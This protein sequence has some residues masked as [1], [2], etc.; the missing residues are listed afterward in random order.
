MGVQDTFQMYGVLSSCI[1]VYFT[2]GV[3]LCLFAGRWLLLE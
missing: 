1:D 3:Q 2:Q